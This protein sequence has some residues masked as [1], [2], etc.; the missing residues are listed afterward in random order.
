M[1]RG[2]LL[3][4]DGDVGSRLMT[5]TGFQYRTRLNTYCFFVYITQERFINVALMQNIRNLIQFLT[6]GIWQ[7]SRRTNQKWNLIS[8]LKVVILS[9][10][11]CFKLR[12]NV[13]ASALTYYTF[14]AIIPILAF[15]IAICRGFGYEEVIFTNLTTSLSSATNLQ[16]IQLVF[17]MIESYLNHAK[18]GVFIGIGI[19]FLLWSVYNVFSQIEKS[20]NEIWGITNLRPIVRR[21]TDYFSLTLLIP[22]LLIIS[23]GL[24]IY[25]N[26]HITQ[27]TG[28]W[29]VD[30]LMAIKPWTLSWI[31]C[32]MVYMVI[33][34]TKVQFWSALTAGFLAGSAVLIFKELFF[35]FM[36]W[37]TSYNAV[38]GSMAIIPVL[39]LFL[40]IAWIIILCGA[41]ISYARQ[42]YEMYEFENE[43]NEITPRYQTCVELYL[44]KSIANS[45]DNGKTYFSFQDLV[46]ANNIP[47]RLLSI[48][49]K[50]LCD[51]KILK[52]LDEKENQVYILNISVT[53]LT[54]GYYFSTISKLGHEEFLNKEINELSSVWLF[55]KEIDNKRVEDYKNILIKSI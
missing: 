38:Y 51:C 47:P 27:W 35:F 1:S 49:L 30:I 24:T 48:V 9:V 13:Q 3:E 53:N 34:N 36:K 18:G 4:A 52:E 44:L 16:T 11:L 28:S 54:L 17:N 6:V 33:P 10:K 8:I 26:Y 22:F 50:H 14:F 46:A 32:T 42:K 23:S 40:R 31:I 20:I 19:I 39:M 41:E 12:I 45:C 5:N 43:I 55:I 2:R 21:V 29:V 37:A 15:I 7:E 25:F